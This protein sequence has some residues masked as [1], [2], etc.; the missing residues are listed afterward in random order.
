MLLKVRLR[1]VVAHEEA[2]PGRAE[3]RVSAA[4]RPNPLEIGR[5]KRLLL[6]ISA[7]S[8]PNPLEIGRDG[9]LLGARVEKG[10]SPTRAEGAPPI[11]SARARAARRPRSRRPRGG[12]TSTRAWCTRG[13]RAGR[14]RCSSSGRGAR[15]SATSARAGRR[16]G[17]AATRSSS[18][19]YCDGAVGDHCRLR[20]RR[21]CM[22]ATTCNTYSAPAPLASSRLRCCLRGSSLQ[23]R[24]RASGARWR[25][26]G[27]RRG[28][29]TSPPRPSSPS[30]PTLAALRAG[31]NGRC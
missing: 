11:L 8:R 26:M 30:T 17:R 7:A 15:P 14:S 27:R 28:M 22:Q 9:L 16:C 23:G 24:A 13:A 6:D 3:R 21:A 19:D 4:S 31:P 1:Q 25:L 29:A 5:D 20:R 2:A 18:H 10:S 12:P